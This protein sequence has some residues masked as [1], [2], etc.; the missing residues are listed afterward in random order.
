MEELLKVLN[1]RVERLNEFAKLGAPVI[2]MMNEI[3]LINKSCDDIARLLE[4]PVD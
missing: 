3:T 2:V 4:K 1:R